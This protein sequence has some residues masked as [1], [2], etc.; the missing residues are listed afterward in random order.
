MF[1]R[2]VRDNAER[3]R[4]FKIAVT[5]CSSLPE[6]YA[7]YKQ[8]GQWFDVNHCPFVSGLSR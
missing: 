5:N 4:T 2:V 3:R 8:K 6:A 7:Q 1:M